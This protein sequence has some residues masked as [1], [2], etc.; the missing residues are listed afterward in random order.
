MRFPTLRQVHPAALTF[1]LLLSACNAPSD[2]AKCSEFKTGH[3]LFRHNEP[4]FHYAAFIDRT[5]SVQTET[6]KLTGD[7]STLSVKWV[8][9]CHYELRL[10]RSTKPYADSVQQMR[11]S[12]P[13]RTE[14]LGGTDHYYLF[15][16]QRRESDPVM[17]DTMWVR[18]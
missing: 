10:L 9:D 3:F 13:L 18:R 4:G 15:Q 16:S 7:V 11:K 8:D 5:D 2:Q 14:I 6:D 17:R 1:S 12:M